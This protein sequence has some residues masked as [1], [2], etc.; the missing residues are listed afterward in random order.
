MAVLRSLILLLFVLLV[1]VIGV[2][3]GIDNSEPVALVFLDWRSLELPVFVWVCL[4][5]LAGFLLG[6]ALTG[7]ATLRQRH[8]RRKA[9]R[10]LEA[11]REPRAQ[12]PAHGG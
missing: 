6:I 5:L 12:K 8:A 3:L 11:S 4:A 1:L 10:A 7:F 2:L 9:E